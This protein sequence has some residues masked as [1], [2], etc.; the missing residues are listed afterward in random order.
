MLSTICELPRHHI[1]YRHGMKGVAR[2]KRFTP[3]AAGKLT[4]VTIEVAKNES[5]LIN[6]R[7]SGRSVTVGAHVRIAEG[8]Q[9]SRHF[10]VNFMLTGDIGRRNWTNDQLTAMLDCDRRS[11]PILGYPSIEHM[12][13]LIDSRT[14]PVEIAHEKHWQ[15]GATVNSI[16]AL[17]ANPEHWTW[18]SY[19]E[20]VKR[21][22]N[23]VPGIGAYPESPSDA[24]VAKRLRDDTEVLEGGQTMALRRAKQGG[25]R[26][27]A[28]RA[29]RP[30]LDLVSLLEAG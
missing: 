23:E 12:V 9:K 30:Q 29:S 10:W 4:S 24:L 8:K 3:I 14:Y 18:E 5:S 2:K 7:D 13:D 6:W 21:L 11:D 16:L 20:L 15:T 25:K 26:S 22:G 17:S 28:I 19:H 1:S 27:D